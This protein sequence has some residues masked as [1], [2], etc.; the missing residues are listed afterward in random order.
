MPKRDD[1]TSVWIKQNN[2]E[3]KDLY[4]SLDNVSLMKS[5][6]IRGTGHVARMGYKRIVYRILLGDLML[7]VHLEYT[8]KGGRIII[9][10][11]FRM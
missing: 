2:E 5:R 3:L 10:W 4:P 9:K 6:R 11:I 7:R 8:D 1:V